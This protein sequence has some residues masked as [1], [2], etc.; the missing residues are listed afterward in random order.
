[1]PT[2]LPWT[3][4][5]VGD[6]DIFAPAVPC[7]LV[8]TWY[9]EGEPDSTVTYFWQ[10]E[11]TGIIHHELLFNAPVSYEEAM[12]WA[13]EHAAAGNIE[14]IHVRHARSQERKRSRKVRPRRA[15]KAGQA[16][17]KKRPRATRKAAKTAKARRRLSPRAAS[18][19]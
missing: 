12:N 17:S 3:S 4:V 13:Q 15:S 1:M 9:V 8:Y 14:R 19:G 7:L 11:G 6:L 10:D 18:K 2:L 5:E 16:S